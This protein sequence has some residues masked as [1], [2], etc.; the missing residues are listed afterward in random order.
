MS[1]TFTRPSP[2]TASEAVKQVNAKPAEDSITIEVLAY[3]RIFK[4]GKVCKCPN[5]EFEPVMKV[6]EIKRVARTGIMMA[7]ASIKK[8]IEHCPNPDCPIGCLRT[9][10]ELVWKI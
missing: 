10:D 8:P 5:C 3:N 9:P 6:T 2:F 4:G 7:L 1:R